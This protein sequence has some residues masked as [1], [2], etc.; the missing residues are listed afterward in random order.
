MELRLSQL[1]KSISVI[2]ATI[3]TKIFSKTKPPSR[4]F[5]KPST[6]TSKP[7]PKQKV[8][9]IQGVFPY[10]RS[11]NKYHVCLQIKP[12]GKLIHYTHKCTKK[13]DK[14]KK[15]NCFSELKH[16]LNMFKNLTWINVGSLIW[17]QSLLVMK[18]LHFSL[19][20]NKLLLLVL[21]ESN[22]YNLSV[23]Q[24]HCFS[25]MPTQSFVDSVDRS[26][27]RRC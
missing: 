23:F 17:L 18:K 5:S 9:K 7:L 20:K 25:K 8:C 16:F 11:S 22:S 27:W 26:W 2:S 12:N 6:S 1:L 3:H 21:D 19:V 10:L 14:K 15:K 4:V 13:S 24:K